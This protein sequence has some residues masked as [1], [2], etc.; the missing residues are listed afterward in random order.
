MR[1]LPYKLSLIIT[2]TTALFMLTGCAKAPEAELA[3]AR[4]AVKAAKDAGADIYMSKNFQ[5]IQKALE[6]AESEVAL[7]EQS[8][9]LMRKYKRSTMLL[10]KVTSLAT[11]ISNETPKIKE[12]VISQVKENLGLVKGMLLETA[13]DIKKASR[14]KKDK[15]LIEELKADLASAES[16]SARAAEEFAAGNALKASE[17][18]SE[19]QQ[20]IKKITDTLKPKTESM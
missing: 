1:F 20:L 6:N 3:A 18:L 5:N 10:Q 16:A 14:S 9:P 12:G 19:V 4:A 8:F 11:E 13:D 17:S 2:G 15:A 7:Q